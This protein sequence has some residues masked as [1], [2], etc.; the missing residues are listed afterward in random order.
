MSPIL[1]GALFVGVGLFAAC[2]IA[3]YQKTSWFQLGAPGVAME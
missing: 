1:K 2:S 3:A